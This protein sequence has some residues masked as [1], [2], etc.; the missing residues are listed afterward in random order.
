MCS[1]NGVNIR[2]L[3]SRI[4]S[5]PNS[6]SNY[7]ALAKLISVIY[8]AKLRANTKRIVK[9]EKISHTHALNMRIEMKESIKNQ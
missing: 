5:L 1:I 3:I 8:G 2:I 7:F 9:Y 4:S 6:E